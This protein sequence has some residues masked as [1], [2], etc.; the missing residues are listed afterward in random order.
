MVYYAKSDA[1]IALVEKPDAPPTP[2]L[3]IWGPGDPR[4]TLPIAGWDPGTGG[5]PTPPPVE[6]L[7]P[8]IWGPTDPRPT[9]PIAEPPWGWGGTP[10]VPPV[11]PPD[12]PKFKVTYIWTAETGWMTVIIP[13]G[14]TATPSKRK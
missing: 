7:P 13:L 12:P 5:W 10:P 11:T 14:P 4:P 3:V 9:V 6:E 1:P 8:T 2:P